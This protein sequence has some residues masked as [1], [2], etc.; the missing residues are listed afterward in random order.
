MPKKSHL[1]SV[2]ASNFTSQEVIRNMIFLIRGRKV[3][4]DADLA[5]LYGVTTKRLNE[6]VKR[7]RSRFPEDFM[8]KLTE[9]ECA[10]LRSQFATSNLK[11][12]IVTSSRGGRRYLPFAFTE[13]GVAM[14]SS[15]LN[16]KRAIQV[17]IEIMR[18]FTQLRRMLLTN[19]DLRR[20]IDE[21]EKK[22]DKQFLIVFNELR[23]LLYEPEK[24]KGKL[25]F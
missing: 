6:Q 13:Q 8:F 16:S 24:P 2:P 12:Q 1:K 4:L 23:K 19:V 15:V 11:S 9:N 21:M 10:S 25:G 3:M 17:N 18:A 7:N 22:Y 14:L 5:S 20:K